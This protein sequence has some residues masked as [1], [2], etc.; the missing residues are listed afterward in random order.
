LKKGNEFKDQFVKMAF[1]SVRELHGLNIGYTFKCHNYPM[2]STLHILICIA[3]SFAAQ[4][5]SQN[6]IDFESTAAGV[7]SASNS[8]SGWTLSSQTASIC[9][10]S[11]V[12][13]PE[14]PE[15]SI[16]STPILSF[17]FSR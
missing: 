1:E 9:N 8:M 10:N 16:V 17:S 2:K 13:K 4:L 11:A 15:F 3:L 14:S 5:H 7:Y 12:W 6:N